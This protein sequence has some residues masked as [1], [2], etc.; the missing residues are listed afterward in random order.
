MSY[1]IAYL[2][3]R[4]P[5]L[6][7]TFIL[8]EMIE[9]ER[10]GWE[11]ALYPL[12]R[13][14]QAVIHQEARAWLPR[15]RWLPYFSPAVLRAN[16]KQLASDPGR[17]AETASQALGGNLFSQKFLVRALA[18]LPKA[19]MAA[20]QMQQEGI[21][22]IHAHYATH[23]ALVAWII[24]RLTGIRYSLSVHAHDI[25][26]DTTMLER[27]L[28]GAEFIVAISEFNRDYLARLYGAWILKKIHVIHCGIDLARY[29]LCS[30]PAQNGEPF[31]LLAIGSLQPYKG[32]RYLIQAC[33]LLKERG[34]PIHCR[35]I[36]EGGEH[37]N[38][39]RQ[40]ASAGL[41]EQVELLGARSQEEV[42]QLL[43]T[44]HAYVQPS[45]VANRGKM[46]GIPVALMEAL[47]CQLPVVATRLSGVPELV[48]PDETGYLV[49]PGDAQA[50]AEALAGIYANPRQAASLA[51]A[52]RELVRKEFELQMNVERLAWLFAQV[53]EP[54]APS[55]HPQDVTQWKFTS[56]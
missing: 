22:H 39:E 32:H 20:C 2:V 10:Q 48:H 49:P 34:L 35:I 55:M 37:R 43:T 28:Q 11:I 5:H 17:F 4:F 7:E 14:H 8:R 3:S 56:I 54:Q 52:G 12:I 53:I 44:A 21:A 40:I 19:I 25:F 38:L 26:V 9:L 24:H 33:A 46:E 27:K 51:K 15:A 47:A 42:A 18:L 6:P 45:V 31:E 23:P 29:R 13:Q 1:K 41:A 16:I 30:G 36:G 50:L